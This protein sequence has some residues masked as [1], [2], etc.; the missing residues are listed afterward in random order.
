MPDSRV[1]CC[2]R[3]NDRIQVFDR[4][5]RWLAN[6]HGLVRPMA[7]WA[8]PDGRHVYVTE[9]APRITRLDSQGRVL[10]RGRAFGIYAHGLAGDAEGNLFVAEQGARSLIACYRRLAT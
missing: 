4:D 1:L 9:Q 6:W 3:D 8:P 7:L 2:D 10:G 5:G